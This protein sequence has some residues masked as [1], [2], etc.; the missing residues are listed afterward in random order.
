MIIAS[1]FHEAHSPPCFY[2]ENHAIIYVIVPPSHAPLPKKSL[3]LLQE[4]LNQAKNYYFLLIA[5]SNLLCFTAID[6]IVSKDQLFSNSLNQVASSIIQCVILNLRF[7]A[8][9]LRFLS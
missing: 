3:I 9:L 5:S 6:L 2:H 8:C 1:T 4:Q 7:A